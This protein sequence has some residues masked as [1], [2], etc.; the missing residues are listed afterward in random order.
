MVHFFGF[1]VYRS[2]RRCCGVGA[3]LVTGVGMGVG[4]GI[5]VT[6]LIISPFFFA[7]YVEPQGM[8]VA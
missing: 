2:D 5:G 3:G 8:S 4:W 1:E 7:V 6:H